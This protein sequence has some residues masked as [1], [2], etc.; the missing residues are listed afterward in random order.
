[1]RDICLIA[2]MAVLLVYG[3]HIMHQLE[4]WLQSSRFQDED[5]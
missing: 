1:M 3:L 2:A 5:D 4:K